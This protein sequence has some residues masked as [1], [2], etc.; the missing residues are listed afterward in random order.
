MTEHWE[1]Q[2][3][4]RSEIEKMREEANQANMQLDEARQ[5]I[6]EAKKSEIHSPE[7]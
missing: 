4:P 2:Q 3:L 5:E 6:V 1:H 7:Q